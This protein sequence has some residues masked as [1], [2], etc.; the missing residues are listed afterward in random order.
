MQNR[1]GF[2]LIELMIVVAILGILAAVAIPQYLNYI[3]R[4]KINSAKSNYEIAINLV[5]SEFAKEAAGT[6][7]TQDVVSDLNQGDKKSP[8]FPTAAAFIE[9]DDPAQDG[10]V[11]ISVTDL[12]GMDPTDTVIVGV[13]WNADGT[14]TADHTT[15]ITKE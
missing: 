10:Q 1:K 12:R 7:A 3:A 11:A 4:S 15:S 13:D 8:M 14:A 9:A 5:K 2:T 6:P